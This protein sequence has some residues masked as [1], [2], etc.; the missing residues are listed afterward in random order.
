MGSSDVSPHCHQDDCARPVFCRPPF[1]AHF[2]KISQMSIS[3]LVLGE[4]FFQ[5]GLSS[6]CAAAIRANRLRNKNKPPLSV[7]K[8]CASVLVAAFVLCPRYESMPAAL[9]EVHSQLNDLLDRS[10]WLLFPI[11]RDNELPRASN[12]SFE[13]LRKE[14]SL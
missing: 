12:R 1:P 7:R 4:I 2:Q 8:G 13:P 3:F 14:N 6:H 9:H 10:M 5:L 11:D